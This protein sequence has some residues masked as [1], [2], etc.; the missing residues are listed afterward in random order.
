MT[1]AVPTERTLRDPLRRFLAS[2]TPQTLDPGTT[3]PA[4]VLVPL[5]ELAGEA[6]IWLVRRPTSMRSHAG[7][8]AF[9]GGKCDAQDDSRLGTAL[10]E[11][12]EELGIPPSSIDVLGVLDDQRTTTGFTITPFVGWLEAGVTLRPNPLEVARVFAA[13]VR[14]FLSA[15]P[16]AS[17]LQGLPV[18]GELV[19]GATA[20]I[21]LRLSALLRGLMP[22]Q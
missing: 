20:A 14:L 19:W 22:N 21:L 3:K 11:T 6:H 1:Q 15:P 13:P 18:D 7:Q 8:V 9:P 5:F 10:R 2:R 16:D 4:A 12:E 17:P